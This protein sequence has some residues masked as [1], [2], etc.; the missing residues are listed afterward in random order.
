MERPATK[1]NGSSD[2]V[3]PCSGRRATADAFSLSSDAFRRFTR[4]AGADQRGPISHP[5]SAIEGAILDGFADVFGGDGIGRGEIGER[6]LPLKIG[7]HILA[8]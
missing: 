8:A 2:G 5:K 1:I 6:F 4:P 7:D 3:R